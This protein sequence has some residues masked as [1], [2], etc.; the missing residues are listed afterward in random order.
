MKKGEGAKQKKREE[1]Y[2]GFEGFDGLIPLSILGLLS[3]HIVA[4]H[5]NIVDNM[6][7]SQTVQMRPNFIHVRLVR[8]HFFELSPVG[9]ITN[10]MFACRTRMYKRKM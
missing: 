1:T 10:T 5:T 4:R 2:L 9:E 6:M 3:T 8:Q 7:L